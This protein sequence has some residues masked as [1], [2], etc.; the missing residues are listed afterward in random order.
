M[1]LPP[2]L[3]LGLEEKTW[4]KC[5]KITNRKPVYSGDLQMTLWQKNTALKCAADGSMM[6]DAFV[7]RKVCL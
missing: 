1:F 2:H 6:L 4:E 5:Q 7:V 3:C